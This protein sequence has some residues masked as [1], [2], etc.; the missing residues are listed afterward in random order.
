[1]GV[2]GTKDSPRGNNSDG[3]KSERLKTLGLPLPPLA[4][5]NG[6][7]TPAGE[8]LF[9]PPAFSCEGVQVQKEQGD[10]KRDSGEGAGS[11]PAAG[12][13]LCMCVCARMGNSRHYSEML[14]V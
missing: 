9:V 14:T 2:G 3:L 7:T 10:N 5:S 13:C 12:S 8:H 11:V 6:A 4:Q 1:M